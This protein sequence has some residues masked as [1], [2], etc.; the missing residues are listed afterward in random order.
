MH[1][2]KRII[3]KNIDMWKENRVNS[4][5]AITWKFELINN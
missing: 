2:I 3:L 1:D 4:I 5:I